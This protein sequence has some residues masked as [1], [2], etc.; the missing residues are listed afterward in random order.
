MR[1]ETDF[2]LSDWSPDHIHPKGTMT[3][4]TTHSGFNW[5]VFNLLKSV[6]LM[7]LGCSGGGLVKSIIDD[8]GFA[9]GIEGS[10]YSK[11]R[12]RAEWATIP[13]NLFNADITHPFT[14]LND[15]NEQVK[16]NVITA[17]E[18]LEH[19][20]DE[21][22]DAMMS[23]IDRHLESDGLFICSISQARDHWE[24]YDYHVNIHPEAWWHDRLNKLGWTVRQDVFNYINPDWVRGPMNGMQSFPL[25]VSR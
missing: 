21:D 23:N 10:D 24:G 18:V 20:P 16:F 11:N 25:V 2:P 13:G 19:I 22:I 7:D 15:D 3:D 8:G 14:V 9:V 6:R 17:W 12:Q 4:N 5:K 1:V